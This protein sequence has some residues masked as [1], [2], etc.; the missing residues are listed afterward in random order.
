MENRGSTNV[1]RSC[2]VAVTENIRIALIF[3]QNQGLLEPVTVFESGEWKYLQFR[4][5]SQA[6]HV[7]AYRTQSS[8]CCGLVFACCDGWKCSE[9]FK[10]EL[11]QRKT[12]VQRWLLIESFVR[13]LLVDLAVVVSAPCSKNVTVAIC[14]VPELSLPRGLYRGWTQA[15]EES[16]G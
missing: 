10:V 7:V 12:H 16:P 11:R 15:W 13:Q 2:N 8:R 9:I 4:T 14:P 3:K 5:R 1:Y 6:P